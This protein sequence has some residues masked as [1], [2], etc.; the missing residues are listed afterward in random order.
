MSEGMT[1]DEY[2]DLALLARMVDECC[3]RI[4]PACR[5]LLVPAIALTRLHTW[6]PDGRCTQGRICPRRQS[7]GHVCSCSIRRLE[8][9]CRQVGLSDTVEAEMARIMAMEGAWNG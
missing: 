7:Y 5:P 8:K 2:T 6:G 1:P 9:W 4:T 3:R